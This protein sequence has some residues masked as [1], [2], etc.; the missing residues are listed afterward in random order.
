MKKT[1]LFVLIFCTISFQSIARA[2][3]VYKAFH[4]GRFDMGLSTNYFKTESNY[5]SS[6][7]KQAL[8]SGSSLQLMSLDTSLRYL[9]FNDL[10]VYTGLNFNNVET[11]NGV[12]TRTNSVLTHFY[13]GSDYQ[14]Y[15]SQLWS[16]YADFSYA[17]ANENIN[18]TADSALASD[19]ASEAKAKIVAMLKSDSF[20]SFGSVG[21]DYRT[22][23]LSALLT[24]G[25]GG[26]IHF[27]DSAI[28]LDLNGYTSVSDDEKTSTPLVR[29]ALTTRV[30]A[31][32]KRFYSINPNLLDSS[33]YYTYSFDPDFVLKVSAGATLLGS[34]TAEGYHAGIAFNWGFGGSGSTKSSS[35]LRAP[36]KNVEN[37][38]G[39]PDT[40]PGFQMDTNDGVNQD[41]FKKIEPSKPKK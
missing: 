12:T 8:L 29:D 3:A 33:V 16:L 30:N 18:T 25:L 22:E 27:S 9:F 19:G 1:S 38:S 41:L 34:N 39:L 35:R 31:G 26:E 13:A 15:E 20:K 36:V 6:G 28:G 5:G 7:D 24:Y 40:E 23:G 11:N 4:T 32:S 21:Y 37:K 10:G 14:F 17:L 2:E